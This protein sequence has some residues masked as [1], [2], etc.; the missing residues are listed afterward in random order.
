MHSRCRL[1]LWKRPCLSRCGPFQDVISRPSDRLE[2]LPQSCTQVCASESWHWLPMERHW[3]KKSCPNTKSIRRTRDFNHLAMLPMSA[4]SA[5]VPLSLFLVSVNPVAAE[6]E[7]LEDGCLLQKT[8]E[9][10]LLVKEEQ[11]RHTQTPGYEY[12]CGS[13]SRNYGC[14]CTKYSVEVTGVTT[15][16]DCA[17]SCTGNVGFIFAPRAPSRPQCRC[18]KNLVQDYPTTYPWTL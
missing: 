2:V 5:I 8:K 15:V 18:C 9:Q 6:L 14:R 4:M 13:G 7:P 16:A 11:R 1:I 12:V 3:L 10:Q 17:D